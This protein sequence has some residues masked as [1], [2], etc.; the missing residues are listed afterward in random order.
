MLWSNFYV[1]MATKHRSVS[2]FTLY[3]IYKAIYLPSATVH[4]NNN[5]KFKIIYILFSNAKNKN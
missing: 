1:T 5:Y 4:I 2:E 3:V